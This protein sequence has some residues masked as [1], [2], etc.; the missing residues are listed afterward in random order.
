MSVLDTMTNTD[1][2]AIRRHLVTLRALIPLHRLTTNERRRIA[3]NFTSIY[4]L[5]APPSVRIPFGNP[6]PS[7]HDPRVVAVDGGDSSL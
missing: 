5:I 1:L 6:P 7:D 4:R 3:C 2:E